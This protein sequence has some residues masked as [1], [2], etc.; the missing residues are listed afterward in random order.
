MARR[1]REGDHPA[2]RVADQQV[3]W[4]DAGHLQQGIEI[5]DAVLHPVSAGIMA[6]VACV[7]AVVVARGKVGEPGQRR[8][9]IRSLSAHPVKEHDRGAPRAAA[10]HEEAVI[11][12]VVHPFDDLAAL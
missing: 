7:E 5:L 11:P 8:I 3:G 10:L 9:P 12:H 2:E 4:L 6:A 1:V